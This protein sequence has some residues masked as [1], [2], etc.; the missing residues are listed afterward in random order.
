VSDRIMTDHYETLQ[1]HPKA[2][3]EAIRDAYERLR[4]RYNPAALEGAADELV[5]LARRRRDEIERAFTV[6]NDPARR[7]A[8]DA[9]L[10]ERAAGPAIA[11]DDDAPAALTDDELIDYRPLPPARRQERPKG[12]NAQ[13]VVPRAQA[14]R[15]AGRNA[16]PTGGV[17][18]WLP[19]TLVVA[20]ATFGVVLATLI[21][22][23]NNPPAAPAQQQSGPNILDPT[24]PAATPT[25]EEIVNRFEGQV[26]AARQVAQRAPDNSN[27]WVELGNAL[28]DSAVVVR[29]RLGSG[30]DEAELQ[31][32]YVERLPRWAEAAD[33]YRKA[34]AIQPDN[35]VVRSSLAAS[36]CYFGTDTN[37]QSYVSQG[38]AEAER[39]AAAAPDEERVLL[40]LGLCQ[41]S[42]DPPQTA[43]ALES[44]QR[45]VA[46]PDADPNLTFQA[47]LLIEQYSK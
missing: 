39:A 33:A 28:Y 7:A 20:V 18:T 25:T 13:P 22:T 15:R 45:L 8:Y 36:L 31:N 37:D 6:L 41:V 44:W 26:V 42:T 30:P 27:A 16:G 24:A 14:A 12:F 47:R 35:A 38:V 34:L 21:S 9:E 11:V 10:A 4:Q 19:P 29:E 43:A 40:S 5:A 32:L 17:P 46:I 2:D 3:A 23:I 1:V